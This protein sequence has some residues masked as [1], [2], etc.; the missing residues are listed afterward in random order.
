MRVGVGEEGESRE[1]RG[2]KG[3]GRAAS[4]EESCGWGGWRAVGGRLAGGW[5]MWAGRGAVSILPGP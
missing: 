1:L 3:L 2:G 5:A 4:A